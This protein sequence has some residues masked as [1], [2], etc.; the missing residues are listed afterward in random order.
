MGHGGVDQIIE[1]HRNGSD[2]TII[3]LICLF[4]SSTVYGQAG[5]LWVFYI[6]SAGELLVFL[7]EKF[8][9]VSV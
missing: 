7:Y 9:I 5:V 8:P 3:L 1:S 6:M 4:F 2:L